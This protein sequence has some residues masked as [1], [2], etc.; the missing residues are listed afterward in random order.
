MKVV[1]QRVDSA[2]VHCNGE[3]IAS[4]EGGLVLY[5]GISLGETPGGAEWLIEEIRKIREPSDQILCLSQFTLLGVFNGTKPS[6]HKAEKPE[7]AKRYFFEVFEKIKEA[8]DCKVERG[9]FGKML[10]VTINGRS[11]HT[12]LLERLID[13]T[14][15]NDV[16]K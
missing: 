10:Q 7:I 15:E 5:I 8:F 16:T 9:E 3:V 4:I 1:V 13:V 12:F 6:F 11:M 2:V 14:N